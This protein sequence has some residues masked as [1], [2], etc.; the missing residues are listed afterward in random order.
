[1]VSVSVVTLFTEGGNLVTLS[2]RQFVR[3]CGYSDVDG[4]YRDRR[5][6]DL[7]AAGMLGVDAEHLSF[8]EAL[9]RPKPEARG[10][11]LRR[12]S[13]AFPESAAIYPTYRWH[14]SKGTIAQSDLSTLKSAST[15]LGRY[16]TSENVVALCP[17]GIGDHVDHVLTR[18]AVE[19]VFQPEQIIYYADQPY[20]LHWPTSR[21]RYPDG[22]REP[23]EYRGDQI[24]KASILRT[25]AT[26]VDALFPEGMPELSEFYYAYRR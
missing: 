17:L 16:N 19:A 8:V 13:A 14:A 18:T 20:A 15:A 22:S 25:Y 11:V 2:G 24:R 10:R 26:Q 12:M 9:Y 23:V 3:Q 4:L 7:V 1:M 21:W 6:E 5:A